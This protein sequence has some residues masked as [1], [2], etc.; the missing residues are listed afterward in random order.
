M[1]SCH[2]YLRIVGLCTVGLLGNQG[3]HA[4]V[5][6][7]P[8]YHVF[9]IGTSVLVPDQ[10]SAVLG[11]VNR[12]LSGQSSRGWPLPGSSTRSH[13]RGSRSAQVQVTILDHREW[14]AAV[15]AQA[16]TPQVATTATQIR[17]RRISGQL[18]Q[19]AT[20][21][22]LESTAALS[23]AAERGAQRR[24]AAEDLA[25]RQLIARGDLC[26]QRGQS[27][28]ARIFYRTAWRQSQGA[29]RELARTRLEGL[30]R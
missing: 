3:V 30:A 16:A 19:T 24:Q 20:A 2:A 18:A 23:A 8:S 5:I 1:K 10:G 4:Q 17:A 27:Q 13:V 6:Q 15:L 28:T 29:V 12:A 26:Q 11:G 9:G 25:A 7:L 21:G 14:D 22:P